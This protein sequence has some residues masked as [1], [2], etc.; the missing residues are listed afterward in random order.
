MIKSEN[1]LLN[2]VWG[3]SRATDYVW[4]QVTGMAPTRAVA[5]PIMV[6]QAF[7]DDS[8]RA[9]SFFVLGGYVATAEQWSLFARDWEEM[10]PYATRSSSGQ[11]HFKMSEMAANA[12]R[13]KRVPAFL[14]IIDK[15]DLIPLASCISYADLRAAANRIYSLNTVINF[16]AIC[17]PYM[18]AFKLLM[19]AFHG[20]RSQIT[21][22]PSDE[23]VNFI[24][25][26]QAE[27]EAVIRSWDRYTSGKN[28]WLFGATPRFEDDKQF[29]PLQAADCLAWLVRKWYESGREDSFVPNL[30]GWQSK[31][32]DRLQFFIELDEDLLV[33]NLIADIKCLAPSAVV[34]DSQYASRRLN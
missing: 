22:V 27:K 33:D 21:S 12:D 11:W 5:S 10:L 24:F 19:E 15:Y 13:L 9:D 30:L 16:M 4:S 17:N 1:A 2:H 14:N 29:L 3:I 25:D 28:G 34:F 6:L 31:N 23:P 7:I 18:I 20:G 8:Y 32:R 26:N